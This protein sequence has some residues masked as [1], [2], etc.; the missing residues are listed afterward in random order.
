MSASTPHVGKFARSLCWSM[1]GPDADRP[2]PQTIKPKLQKIS[3]PNPKALALATASVTQTS[4]RPPRPRSTA[5]L[6][7][8]K[9][10]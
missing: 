1:A 8:L 4:H 10:P 7:A 3:P 5:S 9:S 6:E 2:H